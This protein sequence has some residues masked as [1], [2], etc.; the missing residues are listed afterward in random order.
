MINNYKLHC[1]IYNMFKYIHVLKYRLNKTLEI[2][3]TVCV[4]NCKMYVETN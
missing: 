1:I 4:N 3:N 2:Y